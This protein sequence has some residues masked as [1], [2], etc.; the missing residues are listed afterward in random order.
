[1]EARQLH[2]EHGAQRAD[3]ARGETRKQIGASPGE[4]GQNAVED[5]HIESGMHG[6]KQFASAGRKL[7]RILRHHAMTILISSAVASPIPPSLFAGLSTLRSWRWDSAEDMQ[8]YRWPSV[9]G[10]AIPT[11]ARGTAKCRASFPAAFSQPRRPGTRSPS[12]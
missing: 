1:D 3:L 10:H 9:C 5:P 12:A 7:Q 6:Q 4:R 11:I 8:D 2:I